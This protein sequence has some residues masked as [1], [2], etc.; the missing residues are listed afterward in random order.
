MNK[1]IPYRGL[2]SRRRALGL[3]GAAATL[4]GCG[5][6]DSGTATT[7]TTTSCPRRVVRSTLSR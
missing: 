3:F 5:G 4:Y 6:D 2:M 1:L 7:T